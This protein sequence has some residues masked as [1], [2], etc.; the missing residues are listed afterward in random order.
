[1]NRISFSAGVKALAATIGVV[2]A[3]VPAFS[4]SFRGLGDLG[5]GVNLS[6][7]S[8]CSDLGLIVAGWGTTNEGVEAFFW[9]EPTGLGLA[10]S[11]DTDP[12]IS[13]AFAISADGSVSAGQGYNSLNQ[14]LAF[15]WDF[16]FGGSDMGDLRGGRTWSC[17]YATNWDGTIFA[18][19]ASSTNGREA[20]YKTAR[21]MKALGDLPGG[22]FGSGAT[23]MSPN[24][25]YLAGWSFGSNGR[26]AFTWSQR[27]GM[28]GLG[29]LDGGQ[30][31]SYATGISADGMSVVGRAWSENGREA[32]LWESGN[33]MIG[34]GDLPGGEYYSEALAISSDGTWVVGWS[35]TDNGEEAFIWDETNGMRLLSDA[36]TN[37]YGLDLT[38]WQLMRATG[39]SRDGRAIVGYGLNP[40]GELEA[41]CA[42]IPLPN[43]TTF[44]MDSFTVVTGFNY[45]GDMSSFDAFDGNLF[46]LG[47]DRSSAAFEFSATAP[48]N[49]ATQFEF[50]TAG[51]ATTAGLSYT[52]ELY[53]WNTRRWTPVGSFN[54]KMSDNVQRLLVNT[55]DRFIEQTTNEMRGRIRMRATGRANNTN[56]NASFDMI[57]LSLHG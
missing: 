11:D 3:C 24:G 28:A 47:K 45:G 39:I 40:G 52:L 6:G 8:A 21:G 38:G 32:F 53:N 20:F 17:A 49:T 12:Y 51:H 18:G 1:M 54:S 14:H 33:G 35:H 26:E 2:A 27:Y 56:W 55:P 13:K 29:D 46:I 19:E 30:Y 57:R 5:G 44:A 43:E 42:T 9:S 16:G 34:L 50:A 22:D 4:Q 48:A 10:N 7:A 41:W 37:D 25:A 36:L 23:A 31:D 15:G